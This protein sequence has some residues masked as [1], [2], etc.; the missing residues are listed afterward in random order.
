MTTLTVALPRVRPTAGTEF[1]YALGEPGDADVRHGQAPLALLPRADSLVLVVPVQALSWH[2]VKLPPVPAARQRA[3]LDGLLEDRLLD[4]PATLAL[5][6]APARNSDG[7][8][9]VAAC[10]KAWLAGAL[11]L[12]EQAGRRAR[13]V[14]PALAPLDAAPDGMAVELVVSGPLE[15]PSLALMDAAGVL[16][17]PLAQAREWLDAD[18]LARPGLD[19][20]AE[21]AVAALAEQVLGRPVTVRSPAQALLDS[22]R[23]RWELAQFD[24]ATS[25]HGRLARRWGE[26]A[27]SVLRAPRW[28]ALR[29]GVAAAVVAQVVGL[30]AWAWR[31]DESLQARRAQ[32]RQ[33]LTQT[34]PKVRTVVDAPL[35]MERELALLRQSSGALSPRDLESQLSALGTALTDER[36]ATG[37][38]FAAGQLVVKGVSLTPEQV[39]LASGKLAGQGYA[40]RQEGERLVL[41]APAGR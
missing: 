24:L 1:S 27:R 15:S 41:R 39:S 12:F 25:G 19:V 16:S 26:G 10:D 8:V 40:L 28:R 18:A 32:V 17:V 34:F 36:F 5:A 2:V 29:W 3:A 22:A 20:F 23:S 13:R 14:V 30:N 37:L 33:L 9:V 4:D 31:L 21:P 7:S 35:Q 11:Q 6:L 38:E